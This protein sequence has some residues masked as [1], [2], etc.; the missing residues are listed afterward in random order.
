ML[1]KPPVT[2]LHSEAG[3]NIESKKKFKIMTNTDDN[4]YRLLHNRYFMAVITRLSFYL[5]SKIQNTVEPSFHHL[6]PNFSTWGLHSAHYSQIG[7][8]ERDKNAKSRY[9]SEKI[10]ESV[11][12]PAR[13]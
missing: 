9:S 13:L 10:L 12:F 1:V 11:L 4:K 2:L 3:R 8:H 7:G 6:D 5:C